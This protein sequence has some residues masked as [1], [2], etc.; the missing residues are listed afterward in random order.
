VADP[1]DPRVDDDLQQFLQWHAMQAR[2][3][4]TIANMMAR[5]E[6]FFT[7]IRNIAKGQAQQIHHLNGRVSDVERETEEIRRTVDEHGHALVAIKRRVRTGPDDQEMSTGV[8]QLA[9]IQQRLA[10]QEQKRRDSERVKAEEVVWWK[11][12]IIGWVAGGVGVIITSLVTVL[13]TLAIANSRPAPA[14]PQTA[15]LTAP[16]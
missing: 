16:R 12:S 10:E 7:E 3:G 1:K 8:H 9:A 11:R 14:Q 13:I 6:Q 15:P 4:Y 2:E 5:Q